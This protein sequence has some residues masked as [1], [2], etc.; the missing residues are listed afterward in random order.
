MHSQGL[1][2]N[3][4]KHPL[5]SNPGVPRTPFGLRDC[6]QRAKSILDEGR[7]VSGLSLTVG[8]LLPLWWLP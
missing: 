7:W 8:Y 3:S 1:I 6:I 2:P 5:T 4:T